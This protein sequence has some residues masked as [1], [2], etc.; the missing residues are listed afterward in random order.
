M[1]RLMNILIYMSAFLTLRA[2]MARG[3]ALAGVRVVL[4]GWT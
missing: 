4:H 3:Q 2:Q 1:K